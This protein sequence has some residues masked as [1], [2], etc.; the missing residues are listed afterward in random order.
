MS[1]SKLNKNKEISNEERFDLQRARFG[2]RLTSSFPNLHNA[3]AM[4]FSED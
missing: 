3:L 4:G 2:R 1:L